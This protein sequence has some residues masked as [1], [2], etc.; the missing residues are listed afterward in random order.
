MES[1]L[2]AT[3]FVIDQN[4]AV[5]HNS[6]P[7]IPCENY[8]FRLGNLRGFITDQNI[9]RR[10]GWVE[11]ISNEPSSNPSRMPKVEINAKRCDY[12]DRTGNISITLNQIGGAYRIC[13]QTLMLNCS[14]NRSNNS[15]N[16]TES[17]FTE[18]D[19][20]EIETINSQVEIETV[21]LESFDI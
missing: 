21:D 2:T 7:L 1:S 16:Q 5:L 13:P 11:M 12:I 3:C 15:S 19:H 8:G 9:C 4:M 18:D 17:E 6:N 10:Q 20:I 14:T